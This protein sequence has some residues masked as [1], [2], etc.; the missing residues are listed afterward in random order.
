MVSSCMPPA[1]QPSTCRCRPPEPLWHSRRAVWRRPVSSPTVADRAEERFQAALDRTGARDPRN[2][3]RELL[4]SLKTRDPAEYERVVRLHDEELIPAVAEEGSDPLAAWL[5]YGCQL[6]GLLAPG[7]TVQIDPSGLASPYAPPVPL[8]RLVLQLP[9]A[10]REP[11]LLIG[12]PPY[13]S[14]AQRATVALLHK[15]KQE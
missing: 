9:T 7:T 15:R 8:D 3:Y 1:A 4:R 10:A 6:A 2:F 12:I 11:A 13:L 5:G 14:P